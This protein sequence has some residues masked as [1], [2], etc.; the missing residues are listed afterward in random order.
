VSQEFEN[1]LDV[2]MEE[3]HF[4]LTYDN[5]ALAEKD[6]EKESIVD[7]VKAAVCQ[8]INLFMEMNEEEF[9][10]YLP[11]FAQDVWTQLTRMTLNPGQVCYA[12]SGIFWRLSLLVPCFLIDLKLFDIQIEHVQDNLAMSAIRFLTTLVK[13][14]HHG[15]FQDEKV[16]QQARPPSPP[17]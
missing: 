3:F 10:K 13:G 4:Y 11:T 17:A 5:P 6:A 9:A 14:V 8:N 16:L 12:S 15:L 7:A 1:V 2:W